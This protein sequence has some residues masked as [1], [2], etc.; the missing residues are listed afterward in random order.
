MSRATGKTITKD[1]LKEGDRTVQFNFENSR[2]WICYNFE[3]D[4]I[5]FETERR[6]SNERS[7]YYDGDLRCKYCDR[8]PFKLHE[9]YNKNT[10]AKTH[11]LSHPEWQ[12]NGIKQEGEPD[13]LQENVNNSLALL[14]SGEALPSTFIDSPLLKHLLLQLNY[15]HH[16]EGGAKKMENTILELHQQL[17]FKSTRG[18][19]PYHWLM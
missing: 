19:K 3:E 17:Q 1:S 7:W 14:I 6:S 4:G 18:L 9:V 10:K 5:L 13:M 15:V 16:Y 11:A 12:R 8:T 2:H